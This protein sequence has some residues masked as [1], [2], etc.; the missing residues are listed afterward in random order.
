NVKPNKLAYI[1]GENFSAD[2]IV[3]IANYEYLS[4]EIFDYNIDKTAPLMPIDSLVTFSYSD[5]GKVANK[6]IDII[7]KQRTLQRIE[8]TSSPYTT[9]YIEG[10]TFNP[11]G[12]I[13]VAH[14]E[15]KSLVVTDYVEYTTLPLGMSD[16][17]VIVTY[18]ENGVSVSAKIDIMMAVNLLDYIDITALP[19]KIEYSAGE[20]LSVVGLVVTAYYTNGEHKI[21]F[22]WTTDK[23]TSL[24]VDDSVV[25]IT[26]ID[27]KGTTQ[28]TRV[29]HY[30]ITV[31]ERMLED[32]SIKAQPNKL[33]YVDGE[34]FN[35]EGLVVE[36]NYSGELTQIVT[37]YSIIS[38]DSWLS[39]NDTF[40]E[41]SYTESNLTVSKKIPI[42]VT[43]RTL[44]GLE[45]LVYPN[46][47]EY[48]TTETFEHSGLI[49]RAIYNNGVYLKNVTEYIID[50][51]GV[52]LTVD[53]KIISVSYTENDVTIKA[54]IEITV[55]PRNLVGVTITSPALKI[56][57]IE[58]EYLDILGLIIEAHYSDA[59][60]AV[61]RTWCHDKENALGVIDT[62]VTI[63]YSEGGVTKSTSFEI[64]VVKPI[65]IDEDVKTVIAAINLLPDIINLSLD[66]SDDVQYAKGI[67]DALDSEQRIQIYNVD[68]LNAVIE[69]LNQLIESEPPFIEMEYNINY[70]LLCDI[71]I[72][73]IDFSGNPSK[74][75]NSE[76][77]IQLADPVSMLAVEYGYC[78][79]GWLDG[80]TLEYANII[81]S[82]IGDKIYYAV[83]E[84]TDTVNIVFKSYWDKTTQLYLLESVTRKNQQDNYEYALD[85]ALSEYILVSTGKLALNYYVLNID[86]TIVVVSDGIISTDYN[87]AITVYVVT[88][89]IRTLTVQPETDAIISWTFEYIDDNEDSVTIYSTYVSAFTLTVPIGGELNINVINP[90]IKDILIDSKTVGLLYPDREHSFIIETG[91]SNISVEFEYYDASL[92]L[93]TFTGINTR[94]YAYEAQ[95][96]NGEL[97]SADL[98]NVATIFD[99][100][101]DYY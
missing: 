79:V 13:V 25:T 35:P 86:G 36:A 78:F 29:E 74:Y 1:E 50:K 81:S 71:V 45:I 24:T 99:E 80:D 94:I 83:F 17:V 85:D 55:T 21:V 75:K 8:L 43:T 92:V 101:N 84:L 19:N 82:L 10:Q 15:F 53:D 37:N 95:K 67:Y 96:W 76:G 46:K 64:S 5:N 42:S 14:Y 11:A 6:T 52:P 32:I 72:N 70:V 9:A 73:D 38:L 48:K 23:N 69:K 22:G 62:Q 63:S 51:S 47:T 89:E 18:T 88:A 41:V 66:D 20:N 60:S 34:Y 97:S 90:L 59:P 30:N 68:K 65:I 91:E 3:L 7:V 31:T 61:I 49:V 4:Y 57:Y 12:M 100:D 77:D 44:T 33:T 40:I 16:N 27:I 2:G 87:T 28:V 54:N 56:D 98:S 26:Y 58:G 93:I 39:L